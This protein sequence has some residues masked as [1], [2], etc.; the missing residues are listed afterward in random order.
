MVNSGRFDG[1]DS[2]EGIKEVIRIP[3]RKGTWKI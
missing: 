3:E 2:K 1:M